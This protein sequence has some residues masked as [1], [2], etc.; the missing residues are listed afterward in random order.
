[1]TKLKM[2]KSAVECSNHLY[3]PPQSQLCYWTHAAARGRR[4]FRLNSS[5][6]LLLQLPIAS[7]VPAPGIVIRDDCGRNVQGACTYAF[8][9]LAGRGVASRGSSS[10]TWFSSTWFSSTTTPMTTLVSAARGDKGLGRD[11]VRCNIPPTER[12]KLN[13]P[14]MRCTWVTCSLSMSSNDDSELNESA[15]V[16]CVTKSISAPA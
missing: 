8:A 1:M 2:H 13:R 12:G 5:C 16:F 9:R 4:V 7:L 3:P 14:A 11:S 15:L 6:A 10:S